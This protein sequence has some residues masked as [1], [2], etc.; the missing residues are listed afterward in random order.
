MEYAVA[1][2]PVEDI[3]GKDDKTAG[4]SDEVMKTSSLVDYYRREM[5][6]CQVGGCQVNIAMR[7]LSIKHLYD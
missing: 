4:L 7:G 5:R 2:V 3:L 6:G 1:L